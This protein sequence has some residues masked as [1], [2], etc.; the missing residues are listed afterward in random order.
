MGESQMANRVTGKLKLSVLT[1]SILAAMYAPSAFAAEEEVQAAE[2]QEIE[3]IEVTGFRASARENLNAKR[4]ATTVVDAITAEDI[5]KFPDKNIGDALQRIAGVGI[6]RRFGEADGISIRGLDPSLSLTFLN[7]QSISTAQWFEGYRPTRGFRSDMLAAEL[8]AGLE[9]YKSPRADLPEGSIGGTI[10]IKTRKP[11]DLDANTL[12]ASLEYQYSENADRWD[13]ALSGLFSWKSDNEK[14][15]FLASISHQERFTTY[16]GMENYMASD[17]SAAF[18][19]GG[20]TSGATHAT[21]GAGHAIFQQERERNAYNL[22]F[23]YQPTD[24]LGFTLNYLDF[25]LEANNVNSN[26]LVVPGRAGVLRN[27]SA[28]DV[29]SYGLGDAAL[30]H[31]VY[32]SDID[33]SAGNDYWFGPDTFF[34]NT[35]PDAST[36]DLEIEYSHDLFDLHAQIGRTQAQ[37]DIKV[38]GY[39]G[40]IN[41]SNMAKAGL[42]GDEILTLD[43]TGNALGVSFND[44]DYANPASYPLEIRGDGNVH[45]SDEDQETYYQLDL[46][47]P[48]EL[49]FLTSVKTG[50]KYKEHENERSSHSFGLKNYDSLSAQYQTMADLGFVSTK[51]DRFDEAGKANTLECL[52][53]FSL[54]GV[55]AFSLEN[56][57]DNTQL[58]ENESLNDFYEINEDTLAIYAMAEFEA[59]D[60]R[61]K[62]NFGIRYVDYQLDSIANQLRDNVW[63]MGVVTENDYSEVLPSLNVTFDITDDLLLRGA[64]A[65]VM[66]LP[67]YQDLKNTFSYN[68]DT[69]TG[70]AG[71]PYLEPWRA[72]QLDIGIEWYFD[73]ASLLSATLFHKDIDQFLFP[74]SAQET[75]PGE[76]GVFEVS[77]TRNG[78]EGKLTG[79]ELQFQTE[80]AYGFGLI[81]N[82]TYTDA[83]VTDNTGDSGLALPGN[84]EEM[85]NATGYWENDTFSARIMANYRGPWF[86]GY[87][88]GSAV[89]V[90]EQTSIDVAFSYDVTDNLKLSLQGIN[91]T[92]ELYRTKNSPDNWGGIFQLINDNGTRWFLNASV[93]F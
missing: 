77:R 48:I 65:K 59:I 84:S 39:S 10:N 15:G 30:K 66:S 42:S 26:Y 29:V 46:T 64:L 49:A 3:K 86:A 44:F 89:E 21:W 2:Q 51:C 5:G 50:V 41:T 92:G 68:T 58:P 53:L 33:G 57:V 9:V 78:G 19:A 1:S 7:G 45:I 27:A 14:F 12:Q 16:D 32:L 87:R 43:L 74:F 28:S 56:T 76:V 71:N 85:W 40:K 13:P 35:E 54:S 90:E 73:E 69:F 70:N 11:L 52:P 4:F 34:R 61:L 80:F 18:A 83:E 36:I 79:I 47:F 25:S 93:K 88:I 31:D 75:I 20:D 91:L 60:S 81:S 37:G 6:E 72:N 24:S 82:Y 62:G 22:T 23:Q 55:K 17:K 67:N 8:V 38:Y 63:I